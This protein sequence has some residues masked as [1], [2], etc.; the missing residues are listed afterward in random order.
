M[1]YM[2]ERPLREFRRLF[3]LAKMDPV[4][5]WIRFR[6]DFAEL[7]ERQRPRFQEALTR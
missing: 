5:A 2:I 1:L 4:E 3:R 7:P 6:S